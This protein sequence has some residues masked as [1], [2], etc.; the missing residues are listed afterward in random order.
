MRVVF[1]SSGIV[2]QNTPPGGVSLSELVPGNFSDDSVRNYGASKAGNWF[3][4]SEFDR[5]V[6]KDGIVSVTQNPGN[7]S[8]QTYETLPWLLRTSLQPLLHKPIRGAYTMLWT[9]L[10]ADVGLEDGGRYALP[11]GRWHPCPRGDILESLKTKEQGGTGLAGE[12]WGWC[13]E[14]TKGFA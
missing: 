1:T 7:L 10:G 8:T 5:R 4:A 14:V 12:F 13:E 6:R 9:G 3:L 2:D 11:W